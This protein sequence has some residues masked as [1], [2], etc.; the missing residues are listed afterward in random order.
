MFTRQDNSHD[1]RRRR[2]LQEEVKGARR[3]DS[4]EKQPATRGEA[5]SSPRYSPAADIDAQPRITDLIPSRRSVLALWFFAG[6]LVLAGLETLYYYMPSMA[7]HSTDGRVA[8]FDLDGEG[9]LG[10]YFSSL[11]LAA[12]GLVSVLIYAL[13][14]HRLDDYRGRYRIWLWAAICWFVMSIDESGSLHEG[15]KEFISHLTG[16]RLFGD[17]SIW[18]AMSYGLVLGVVGIYLLLE[19]RACKSSTFSLLLSAVSYAVAV[20]AQLQLL[21]PDRGSQ[22]VML[23]EGCEMAGGL[24]LL[25][26]MALHAR[27]VLRDIQGL[28]VHAEESV[29]EEAVE[30]PKRSAKKKAA[31]LDEDDEEDDSEEEIRVVRP[32]A[33]KVEVRPSAPVRTESKFE[34]RG[35]IPATNKVEVRP[36]MKAEAAKA[37]A[38]PAAK[39][40]TKTAKAE[41]VAEAKP[42]GSSW[43]SRALGMAKSDTGTKETSP[44]ASKP[45]QSRTDAGGESKPRLSKAERKAMKRMQRADRDDE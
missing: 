34:A 28:I 29:D 33:S 41:P 20:A 30:K 12:A 24:L 10:A 2:L 6:V 37:E 35:A 14:R 22:G 15:F 1:E 45:T 21:M 43:F 39:P 8:A 23:E 38:R 7:K 16:R 27:Y 18:W 36:A 5:E 4:T 44:P 11:V 3:G 13:R 42:A 19:M 9:S 17:G 32:A 25:L 31:E 26:S 40:E